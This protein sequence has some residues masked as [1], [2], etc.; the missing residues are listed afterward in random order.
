MSLLDNLK[1]LPEADQKRYKEIMDA[2]AKRKAE[3]PRKARGP[4]TDEQKVKLTE[5]RMSKLQEKLAALK[6]KKQA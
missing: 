4:M 5:G 2:C 3:A 1:S 6:A